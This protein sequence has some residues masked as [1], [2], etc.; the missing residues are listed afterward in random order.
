VQVEYE[1]REKLVLLRR[2]MVLASE[3]DKQLWNLL[4]RSVPSF[5]TLFRHA[6][7][8][9][10]AETNN[11]KRGAVDTLSKLIAFDCSP[12][13]QIL[14]VREGKADRKKGNAKDLSRRYLAA[15]EQVTIAV[16]KAI[17]SGTLGHS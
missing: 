1:L 17:E 14:D 16:D 12:L 8:V 6:A 2:Q 3:D 10:G 5:T 9:L 4:L 11:G 15:I 7:I 13:M